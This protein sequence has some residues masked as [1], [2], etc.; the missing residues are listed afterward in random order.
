MCIYVDEGSI[1]NKKNEQHEFLFTM[2]DIENKM[3]TNYVLY[4]NYYYTFSA[5]Q[6]C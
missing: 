2:L 3:L 5:V 4:N 1:W 6:S